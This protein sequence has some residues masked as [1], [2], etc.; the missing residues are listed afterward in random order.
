MVLASIQ[1]IS[2]LLLLAQD[3][4][5]I[6]RIE[7]AD[8]FARNNRILLLKHQETGIPV[9]I[10]LGVL[11]LEIEAVERSQIYTVGTLKLRLPS[12][13]DLIIFK[14][15]AHRPKDIIDIQA[16]VENYPD[17]DRDRIRTWVKEFAKT[18][19]MPELWDDIDALI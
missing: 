16:I 11:P 15:V 8:E 19:D 12:P 13:E 4:G 5:L 9:D 14:A 18:L 17:L 6:P 3:V 7:N 1:D 2:N 10:S